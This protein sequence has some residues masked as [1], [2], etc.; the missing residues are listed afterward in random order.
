MKPV[1]IVVIG[2]NEGQRLIRCLNALSDAKIVVYV[3]SGSTDGSVEAALEIG[4]EVVELDLSIPF[5]AARARNVGFERL[6]SK[7]PDLEFVQF[8]DGDCILDPG[9]LESAAGELTNN[10]EVAFVCGRLHE[11]HRHRNIYSKL[12][13]KEWDV[14]IGDV[15]ACGGI[16]M[17]RARVFQQVG[18]FCERLIAGEEPELCL[19]VR[20]AGWKILRL[21]EP[22]ASHDIAMT[23]FSQWWKRAKRAGHAYA[24]G[25]AL[26]GYS[27]FR[28]KLREVRSSL[29]WGGLVPA[30]AILTAILGFVW[31]IAWLGTAAAIAGYGLLIIRI[32][33]SSRRR[34]WS[35]SDSILYAFFCALSKPAAFLG[36]CQYWW[37]QWRGQQSSLI[38]YK[39][40][41]RGERRAESGESASADLRRHG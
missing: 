23:R 30:F 6:R 35:F 32:Y 38:E 4:C 37:N 27:E 7:H 24:E 13:D 9:W 10:P 16:F 22:M 41:E 40:A 33:Q 39:E 18:N 34:K 17:A 28:H 31:P 2:R 14:P 36:I 20:R 21:S 29:F 26:H 19:R 12:A 15:R 8:I 11:E 25:A 1:G 5:T 3:D